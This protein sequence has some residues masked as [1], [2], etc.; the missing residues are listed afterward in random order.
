[1]AL[2]AEVWDW[3]IHIKALGQS[4]FEVNCQRKF[5]YNAHLNKLRGPLSDA[6]FSCVDFVC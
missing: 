2:C 6:F 4:L 5:T 3:H 1:M